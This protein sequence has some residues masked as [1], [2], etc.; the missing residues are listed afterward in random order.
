M[1]VTK[2]DNQLLAQAK[3]EIEAEWSAGLHPDAVKQLENIVVT[4]TK[5]A[6]KF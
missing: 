3:L 5:S 2:T 1:I 6:K 4:A